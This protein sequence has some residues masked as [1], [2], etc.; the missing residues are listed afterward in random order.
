MAIR[1]VVESESDEIFIMIAQYL[2]RE[3]LQRTMDIHSKGLFTILGVSLLLVAVAV[4]LALRLVPRNVV[5]G[6]RTRETLA[7]DRL[8]LSVNAYF[9]QR[10]IV[11]TSV[12]CTLA[13]VTY[14]IFPLPEDLVVPFSVLC[15]ALPSLIATLA[16]MRFLRR[17]QGAGN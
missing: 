11:A 3:G 15:F 9:G 4:P 13:I 8:W 12:G 5:Y 16:T 1:K 14:L 6:F 17:C 7:D 10:L 2:P